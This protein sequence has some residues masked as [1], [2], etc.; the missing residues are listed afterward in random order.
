ME[1]ISADNKPAHEIDV[2]LWN[3]EI[4][5]C[6]V[7]FYCSASKTFNDDGGWELS[8]VTHWMPLPEPPK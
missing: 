2:L 7:G 8:H 3:D 4:S 1:W 5:C 6:L